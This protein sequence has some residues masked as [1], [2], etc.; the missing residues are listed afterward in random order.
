MKTRHLPLAALLA[1][2]LA[3]DVR[4]Q[5][6]FVDPVTRKPRTPDASEMHDLVTPK[7]VIA[8]PPLKTL[9]GPGS[10]VG[11]LLDDS[12]ASYAVVARRSDGTLESACVTGEDAIAEAFARGHTD[13]SPRTAAPSPRIETPPPSVQAPPPRAALPLDVE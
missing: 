7:A 1:L 8:R 6:I 4:A 5:T 10:A 13:S 9:R 12:F 11:V 3:A 2:A